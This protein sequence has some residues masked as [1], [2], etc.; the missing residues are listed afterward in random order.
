MAVVNLHPFLRP[1]LDVLFVALNPPEQSNSNGH[2][3]SG[4]GSRFFQLLH[5]SGLITKAVPKEN[6]DEIVF[7]STVVNHAGKEFGVVDLITGVVRTDSRKVRPT[8]QHVD[9]LL[10]HIRDLDPRFVCIIH[11]KVRDA[12]VK[13]ADL[14]GS[15]TYG[16]C[17]VVLPASAALVVMNYFPNGNAIPDEPK[18]RIF[19]ELR[20]AL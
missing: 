10:K 5:Q 18:L 3:F 19:R 7:G 1:H 17:G 8:K 4:T 14:V 20:D 15:L 2:Y 11:S 13:H 16:I 6:A 9:A 12:L